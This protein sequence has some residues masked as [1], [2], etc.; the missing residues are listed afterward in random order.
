LMAY[1]TRRTGRYIGEAWL[2]NVAG[3]AKN[4]GMLASERMWGLSTMEWKSS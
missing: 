3:S 1:E 2:E 4:S